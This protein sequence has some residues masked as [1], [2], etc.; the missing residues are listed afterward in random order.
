MNKDW[1]VLHLREALEELTRTIAELESEPEYCE[2]KFYV[3]MAHMYSHLNTAWN[4]RAVA[5]DELSCFSAEE[6]DAWRKF[7]SDIEL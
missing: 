4:S 3:A 1:T 6:F 7:P 5:D 2:G